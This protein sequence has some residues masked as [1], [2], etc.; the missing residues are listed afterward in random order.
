MSQILISNMFVEEPSERVEMIYVVN[1][2]REIVSKSDCFILMNLL[3]FKRKFNNF[4]DSKNVRI[5]YILSGMLSSKRS[6]FRVFSILIFLL[7]SP[8]CIN[9]KKKFLFHQVRN[10]FHDEFAKSFQ[11][12]VVE[13]YSY[14]CL[15]WQTLRKFTCQCIV[16]IMQINTKLCYFLVIF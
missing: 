6:C 2:F 15:P 7:V 10:N 4:T 16:Q 12:I 3:N 11:K 5:S 8:F 9:I 1:I 14:Y 13:R